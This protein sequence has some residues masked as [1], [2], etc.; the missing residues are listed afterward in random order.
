VRARRRPT[1]ERLCGLARRHSFAIDRGDFGAHAAQIARELPAMVDAVVHTDLQEGDGG[2]LEDAAEVGDLIRCSPLSCVSF[3][4]WR[5]KFSEYQEQPR[6]GSS[7]SPASCGGG[8]SAL[9]V[10]SRK[11]I[12]AAAMWRANSMAVLA[13]DRDGNRPCRRAQLRDLLVVRLSF[14]SVPSRISCSQNSARSGVKPSH[15][16]CSKD[17][18][19]GVYIFC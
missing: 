2:E 12:S 3:S 8:N 18:R 4:K 17:G 9:I 15:F 16:L 13:R 14:F 6:P 5:P 19:T 10:V 1:P 11:R 7:R